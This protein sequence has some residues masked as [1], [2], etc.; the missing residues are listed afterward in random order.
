[1][2]EVD[3]ETDTR[4]AAN[5]I[6][7]AHSFKASLKVPEHAIAKF[8]KKRIKEAQA[9]HNAQR[10]TGQ[11]DTRVELF[12]HIRTQIAQTHIRHIVAAKPETA[13]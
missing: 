3:A 4:L 5:E 6:A 2:R 12:R 7:D 11:V 9:K 8:R 13:W 10:G 1:M